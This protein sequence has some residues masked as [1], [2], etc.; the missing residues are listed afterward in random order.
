MFDKYDKNK[1]KSKSEET[2]RMAQNSTQKNN[3]FLKIMT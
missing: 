3:Y 2:R 1:L